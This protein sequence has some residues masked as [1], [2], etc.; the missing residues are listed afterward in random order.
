MLTAFLYN[1]GI[2]LENWVTDGV[3]I[4]EVYYKKVLK[5]L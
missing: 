1:K 2:I 5:P 4:N 3:T